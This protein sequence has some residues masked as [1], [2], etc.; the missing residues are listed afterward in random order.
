MSSAYMTSVPTQYAAKE[1]AT[2]GA[3][4]QS[5]N[6]D[7]NVIQAQAGRLAAP[8]IS[9][10]HAIGQAAAAQARSAHEREDIHNSSVYQH[11]DSLDKRSQE[12]ENY[13]LG[14]SVISDTQNNAH[15]TFWNDDAAALVKSNP[16]Q[17]EYVNAPNYWKGI[18]Y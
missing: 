13:Q 2:L 15:G 6:V 4:M 5:F 1:R 9:Q 10:I 18:D 12:F 16:N 8:A 7:M 11:W 17:F 14:Y 3:I